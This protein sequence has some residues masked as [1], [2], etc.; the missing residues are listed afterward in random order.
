M[1]IWITEM[2]FIKDSDQ[3]QNK[4]NVLYSDKGCHIL[5]KKSQNKRNQSWQS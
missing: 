3:I 1:V 4:K 5:A 2:R